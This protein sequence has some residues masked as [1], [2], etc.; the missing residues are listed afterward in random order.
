MNYCCEKMEYYLN[1]KCDI[2][3]DPYD[4]PDNV[5]TYNEVYDEYGII[6]HDGTHSSYIIEYCPWCGQKLPESKREKWFETMEKLGI[7]KWKDTIPE[8]YTKWGWWL[9]E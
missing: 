6:I 8:K 4:C 3:P 9:E 7:E 5:V 1:M 2:H